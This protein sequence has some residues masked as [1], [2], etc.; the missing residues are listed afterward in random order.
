MNSDGSSPGRWIVPAD[1]QKMIDC[2]VDGI[3]SNRPDEV[4][5]ILAK[6]KI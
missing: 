6:C 4:V 3:I 2:E 5:R 1:I